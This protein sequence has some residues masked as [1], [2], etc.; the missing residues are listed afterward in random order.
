[1]KFLKKDIEIPSSHP[2]YSSLQVALWNIDY[3]IKRANSCSD[4]W[5]FEKKIISDEK[6]FS[7]KK[8]LMNYRHVV[9]KGKWD[10]RA[11]SIFRKAGINY[12]FNGIQKHRVS[13]FYKLKQQILKYFILP[14]FGYIFSKK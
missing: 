4:I 10:Y 1:M 14:I 6:H 5:N 11:N 7:V 13:I 9:E 2:Y 3:L 12:S 8:N